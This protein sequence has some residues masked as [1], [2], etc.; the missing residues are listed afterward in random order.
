MKTAILIDGGYY[1]KVALPKFGFKSSKE[2][3]DELYKYCTR[4][5][6]EGNKKNKFRNDLYRIFYYD[7][8]PIEKNVY[9]PLLKKDIALGK[10]EHF[11]WMNEF[12]KE[13]QKKRKL[14]LRLGTISDISLGYS[15]KP[16]VLKK[17]LSGDLTVSNLG[18]ND[19][20]F[21]ALQKGVDMKIGVDI[22]SISYKKQV[23]QI[24][25]IAGDSDFVPAAKLARRE[26]VDFILD[27]LGRPVKNNLFEHIDGLRFCDNRLKND[28]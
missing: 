19:F 28:Y 2:S 8:P 3:A 21:S 22:A 10:T 11:N 20:Q 4:H 6:T 7:C 12:I 14:A 24:V 1:R 15:L 5:L 16:K 25:L 18:E 23:D 9:H 17:L 13:L 26:G 27:S